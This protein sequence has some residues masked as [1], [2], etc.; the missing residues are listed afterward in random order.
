MFINELYITTTTYKLQDRD[1]KYMPINIASFLYFT[2]SSAL[3]I[4]RGLSLC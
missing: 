1:G 2:G 4:L 3:L